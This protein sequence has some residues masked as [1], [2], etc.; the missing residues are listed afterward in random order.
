MLNARGHAAFENVPAGAYRLF[1]SARWAEAVESEDC[2]L[3]GQIQDPGRGR[4]ERG[5]NPFALGVSSLPDDLSWT[6]PHV[7]SGADIRAMI[8]IADEITPYLFERLRLAK[9]IRTLSQPR[10]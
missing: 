9:H 8:A 4:H 5:R 10:P 6:V 2:R 3:L 7:M 1:A